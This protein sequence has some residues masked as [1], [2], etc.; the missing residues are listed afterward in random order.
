MSYYQDFGCDWVLIV[1]SFSKRIYKGKNSKVERFSLRRNLECKVALNLVCRC[2]LDVNNDRSM[3]LTYD[4]W[5]WNRST[6]VIRIS[7][8]FSHRP[9]Y[10]WWTQ[11]RASKQFTRE[12]Y[13]WSWPNRGGPVGPKHTLIAE[14]SPRLKLSS[15]LEGYRIQLPLWQS[16]VNSWGNRRQFWI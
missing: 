10:P 2:G 12:W 14:V 9:G 4:S 15:S 5:H 7:K 8:S 11:I 13:S 16:S 1:A 6:R 3:T